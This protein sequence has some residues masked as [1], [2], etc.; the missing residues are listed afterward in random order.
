MKRE[1][2]EVGIEYNPGWVEKNIDA[3]RHTE[4]MKFDCKIIP[5][6]FHD[7]QI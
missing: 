3:L 7:S 2:L 6:S 1:F 5:V 4:V